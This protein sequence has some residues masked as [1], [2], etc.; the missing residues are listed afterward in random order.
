MS[1]G[2][3]ALR[4]TGLA[5]LLFG[6]LSPRPASGESGPVLGQPAAAGAAWSP[7]PVASPGRV[8]VPVPAAVPEAAGA[9]AAAGSGPA[10][11]DSRPAP[12][13][14]P[15]S[16][17]PAAPTAGPAFRSLV[18]A[19]RPSPAGEQLLE[20]D[21]LRARPATH[22]GEVLLGEPGVGAVKRSA[23][24]T[25][26]VLR[27]LGGERVRTQVGVLP[28]AGAC[29]SGM[30]PAV[31]YVPVGAAGQVRLVRGPGLV[32][33]GGGGPGGRIVVEPFAPRAR[34]TAREVGGNFGV[35]HDSLRGLWNGSL[36]LA[37]TLPGLELQGGLQGVHGGDYRSPG[38]IEVPADQALLHGSLGVRV[39]PT[40]TQQAWLQL[41]ATRERDSEFPALPMDLDSSDARLL[42]GGWRLQ[43]DTGLLRTLE[44]QVGGFTVDHVMSNR[45]KSNRAGLEAEAV[46]ESRSTAARLLVGLQPTAGLVVDAGLDLTRLEWDAVRTRRLP[47]SDQTFVD[48]LW[49]R[50]SQTDLGLFAQL[51][52]PLGEWLRLELGLR[53]DLVAS[54]APAA[55]DPSLGGRTLREHWQALY[56]PAA[57]P[58]G[59]RELLGGGTLQLA[60]GSPEQVAGHLLLG[61][62]SRAAGIGER[63]YGFAPSPGGYQIGNP[64]LDPERAWRAEA[65]LKLRR[66]ALQVAGTAHLSRVQDFILPT[67]IEQRDVSGDGLA[68]VVRGFVDT[69]A[70]L[71]GVELD[72]RLQPRPWL[73]LPLT[74]SWVRGQ[75]VD[76]ER[77]LPLIPPAEVRGAVRLQTRGPA[78]AWLEL[79]ARAAAAQT[80]VDERLPEDATSAFFTLRAELGGSLGNWLT[81]GAAVENLLDADYHEHLTREALLASGNLLAGDEIPSPGRSLVVWLRARR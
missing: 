63:Y 20:A 5:L 70:L 19:A 73:T 13:P 30:D 81:L 23:S 2:S 60:A 33:H 56:G 80:R 18:H 15:G 75:D 51:G 24:S 35:L 25:E 50:A 47:A 57:V 26:P 43:Q 72:L 53:G 27:G 58:V 55:S 41:A 16:E 21:E 78:A 44:A 49:P 38:G 14:V 34:P 7:S 17:A 62:T 65:G 79:G 37:A 52:R 31:T 6:G 36:D 61:L 32:E 76:A 29:P 54:Q 69:E 46:T 71:G 67:V 11:A 9:A 12:A 4:G 40:S 3:L 64:T 66:T 74:A 59:R 48:H 42:L 8:A 77:P 22:L 45:H 28:L 1:R 68:D 10:A 39:W